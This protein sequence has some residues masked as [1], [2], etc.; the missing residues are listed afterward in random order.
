[1]LLTF[2]WLEAGAPGGKESVGW[3][4]NE[5]RRQ[6][7]SITLSGRSVKRTVRLRSTSFGTNEIWYNEKSIIIIQFEGLASWVISWV[8]SH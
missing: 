2:F 7:S 8:I 3:S 4:T 1:M 6:T 5:Q